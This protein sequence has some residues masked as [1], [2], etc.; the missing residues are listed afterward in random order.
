MSST[1]GESYSADL[2]CHRWKLLGSEIDPKGY[3]YRERESDEGTVRSGKWTQGSLSF[4]AKGG[5]LPLDFDLVP[6][7]P[8]GIVR[9]TLEAGARRVCVACGASGGRDGSDGKTFLGKSDTC[10]APPSCPAP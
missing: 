2:P 8:Q 5:V 4:K 3:V 7:V 6:G 1:A 10:A 9:L